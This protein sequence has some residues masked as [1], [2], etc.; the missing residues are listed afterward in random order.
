MSP[1]DWKQLLQQPPPPGTTVKQKKFGLLS[2][3]RQAADSSV[4]TAIEP[5]T[6]SSGAVPSPAAATTVPIL[7]LPVPLPELQEHKYEQPFRSYGCCYL[8]TWQLLSSAAWQ[9]H[10]VHAVLSFMQSTAVHLSKSMN[11]Q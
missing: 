7:L 11:L 1:R 3:S 8:R 9:V 4:E 2:A 5:H 10:P 6:F